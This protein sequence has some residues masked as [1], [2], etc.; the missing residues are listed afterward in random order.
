MKC[1]IFCTLSYIPLV[2]LM[3]AGC[4]EISQ[5]GKNGTNGKVTTCISWNYEYNDKGLPSKITSPGGK[6]TDLSYE[7]YRG[8]INNI[9]KIIKKDGDGIVSASF[10]TTGNLVEMQDNLGQVT[11]KYDQLNRPVKISRAHMP[12]IS[13]SYNTSDQMTS[14]EISN[15]YRIDYTY[16]FLGRLTVMNTPAG[17]IT[18][19]YYAGDGIIERL[20]PNGIKTQYKYFADGKLEFITHAEKNGNVL[21]KYSYIYNPDGLI[22]STTEWSSQGERKLAYEYDKVQRLTG[23]IDADGSKTNYSYDEFGNRTEVS[24]NTN[25]TGSYTYD[26][27]GR[28]LACNEIPCEYDNAGN[29][30][31][32]ENGDKKFNYSSSNQLIKAGNTSYEFAGVN[33]K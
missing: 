6:V 21:V 5:N 14:L 15:G 29:L 24:I 12:E 2:L 27:L 10:D 1:R 20:L 17:E 3:I 8:I 7:F 18:Y 31:T 26:G 11:Y 9:K 23:F 32:D 28:M 22:E 13:Y 16:D 30:L 25:T 33:G 19:A 4:G